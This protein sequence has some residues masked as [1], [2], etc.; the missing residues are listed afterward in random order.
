MCNRRT[1][2]W[3]VAWIGFTLLAQGV[4]GDPP[5]GVTPFTFETWDESHGLPQS[6]VQEVGQGEDGYLW[7]ATMG[8]FAR[9]DGAR[10]TVF[11]RTSTPVLGDNLIQALFCEGS[12]VWIGTGSAG[13]GVFENGAFRPVPGS[14]SD[15]VWAFAKGSDGTIWIATQGGLARV[16]EGRINP[17]TSPLIPPGEPIFSVHRDAAGT[18]WAGAEA[19]QLIRIAGEEVALFDSGEGLPGSPIRALTSDPS[20]ALWIGTE[21]GLSRFADGVF[22]TFTADDGLAS[23]VV[24]AL[25]VDR[26]GVLWIGTYGGLTRKSGDR[27]ESYR[28]ADSDLPIDTVRS[29]FEDR[30]GNLWVGTGGGGLSRMRRAAVRSLNHVGPATIGIARTVMESSSGDLW[31]GTFGNGA[32]RIRGNDARSFQMDDGLPDD[33]VLAIAE[34]PA[35]TI[36]LGTRDGLVEMTG[37]RVRRVIRTADGLPSRII[38][39]LYVDRAGTLWIGT[40]AG[41]ARLKDGRIER[42]GAAEGV[43]DAAVFNVIEARDGSIWIVAYGEGLI[44]ILNGNVSR[45]GVESG[46]PTAK[47]YSIH[48]DDRGVL[49]VGSGGGGLIRY[50]EGRFAAIDVR[51][52]LVDDVVY[53]VLEDDDGRL[54]MSGNKGIFAASRD[55]LDS[56]A[57]GES[58]RVSAV[59]LGKSDGMRSP[60]CNGATQPAGWRTRDGRL[61]FPTL[62][63]VALLDPDEIRSSTVA[64]RTVIE[65]VVVNGEPVRL[66]SR[67][68]L[69]P[70]AERLEIHYTGLMMS[71]P[72]RLLFRYR[73]EPLER[74]WIEVGSSRIARYTNLPPGRYQFQVAAAQRGGPWNAGSTIALAIEPHQWETRRFWLLLLGVLIGA[75]VLFVLLRARR[76]RRRERELLQLVEQRTSELAAANALLEE[77]TR[78]DSLTGLANRRHFDEALDREWRRAIRDRSWLSLILIDVD[79][80]KPYNDAYGHQPGDECLR[81]IASLLQRTGHRPGDLVARY[82]GEEFAVILYGAEPSHVKRIGEAIRAGVEREACPHEF[83]TVADV[84]TISAGVASVRPYPDLEPSQLVALADELLYRAKHAGRNR[85]ATGTLGPESGR[86]G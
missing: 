25:R 46:L 21:N 31:V 82:G 45:I 72:E 70:G 71:A 29:V 52:G 51:A 10:F 19:G 64:P 50:E 11:D 6:S 13:V 83:S 1:P 23:N 69:A 40:R 30:E 48:E 67:L 37:G 4:A 34:H 16:E 84:V 9:F 60:E 39:A 28:A 15:S 17:F 41:L 63:G 56:F 3:I 2:Y 43:T 57:R 53:Q 47:I 61:V 26:E 14:P 66:A 7:I 22:T 42:L 85:V 68:D 5:S 32:V 59:G 81:Q 27:F 76:T 54:W 77:Q 73:L 74:E 8:G 44:R 38:R 78:V 33:V 65:E 12:R 58:L 18:I 20:G 36:W 55:E 35:G 86:E 80:F 62:E 79:Q 49:W 75:V 24:R